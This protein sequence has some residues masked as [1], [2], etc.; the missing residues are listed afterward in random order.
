MSNFWLEYLAVS[1]SFVAFLSFALMLKRRRR[2]KIQIWLNEPR[3][4]N[5]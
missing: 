5:R 1:G 2:S 3:K 4:R